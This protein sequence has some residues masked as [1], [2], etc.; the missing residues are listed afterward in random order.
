MLYSWGKRTIWS[1]KEY[2]SAWSEGVK[3]Y[4][5]QPKHSEDIDRHASRLCRLID[6]DRPDVVRAGQGGALRLSYHSSRMMGHNFTE[7]THV[8]TKTMLSE[9]QCQHYGFYPALG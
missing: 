8:D 9:Y 4:H 2:V 1:P 5:F 6:F 3:T 7:K